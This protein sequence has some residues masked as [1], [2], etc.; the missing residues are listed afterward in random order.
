MVYMVYPKTL[1]NLIPR[2]EALC[3]WLLGG[4]WVVIT[5][6]TSRVA[7]LIAHIRRLITPLITSLNPIK[8]LY[9]ALSSTSRNPITPLTTTAE[10][11]SRGVGVLGLEL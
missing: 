1:F 4:S 6:V 3:Y 11:R 7:I 9:K 8:K 5:R 2:T 10:P